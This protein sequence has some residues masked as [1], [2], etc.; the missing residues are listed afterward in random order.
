MKLFARKKTVICLLLLLLTG[1]VYGNTFLNG[2]TYDDIPVVVENPDA[3]SIGGFLAD[4]YPGRPLRELTYIP[5]YK[6][7]GVEPAGYHLQQLFWH[8]A[9]GLL[10]FC[11]FAALGFEPLYAG[12]GCAL[13]LVHPLQ[14]ESV[15][16]IANRKELLALFF[17]LASFLA[18]VR[19]VQSVGRR[20]LAF[21]GASLAGYGVALLANQTAITFPL[22]VVLYD[23]LFLAREER[24]ILKRPLFTAL[25][26]GAMGAFALYHFRYLFSRDELLTIYSK[27]NFLASKS[28]LPLYMADLK[29]FAFYLY[30]IA[31]PANL[32]PEYVIPIS[33][34]PFQ[35]LALLGLTLL[36]GMAAAFAALRRNLPLAAFGVGWYLV[37]Y[38]PVSNIVPVAYIV[39]DR[40]MYICLP[41][42]ALLVAAILRKASLNWLNAGFCSILAVLACLTVLQNGYWQDQHTLWR[43]AVKVN[44]ESAVVQETVANSYLLTREFA[45]A[46]IHA[47]KAIELYQYNMRFYLTLAKIE[48][49]L[50]NLTEA[51]KN[52]EMFVAFGVMEYPEEVAIVKNYL[53]VLRTRIA[54]LEKRG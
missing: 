14:T 36:T 46:R 24:L 45:T 21:L 17:L 8:G 23:Y 18:Y 34:Q 40:Y 42:I 1:A 38:L 25:C 4:S 28:F 7:F 9:N 27:N 3:H 54:W 16:G 47:R 32:A 50:G 41:G 30:K 39:A 5:E 29:A 12:L 15:A 37:M 52:Y 31:V 43:H 49:R 44:P 22:L 35:G 10:L 6:L 33:D 2:W 13:F 51:L 53:P 11:L 26:L 19:A 48:D 20:R